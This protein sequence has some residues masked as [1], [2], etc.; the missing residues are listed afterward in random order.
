MKGRLYIDGKDAYSEYG[1]FVT[2]GGY[3]GVVAYPPLK[4]VK[5]NDWQEMD[6]IEVD[7]SAP[8]L[9]TRQF[10]MDFAFSG[11]LLCGSRTNPPLAVAAQP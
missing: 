10:P 6:G 3:N 5:S 2:E 9:D 8:K 7:L 4:S 11:R 1:V